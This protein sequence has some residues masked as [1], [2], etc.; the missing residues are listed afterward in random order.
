MLQKGIEKITEHFYW[1]HISIEVILS[2]VIGFVVK[3]I[4][5]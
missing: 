4:H 2:L 5:I 1:L 3:Q